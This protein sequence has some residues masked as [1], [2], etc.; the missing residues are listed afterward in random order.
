M[1][2]NKELYKSW[3][4]RLQF[5]D[6]YLVVASTVLLEFQGARSKGREK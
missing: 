3:P 4:E 6:I 1:P 5:Y 2:R